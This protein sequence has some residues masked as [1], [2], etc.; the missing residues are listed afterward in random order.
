MKVKYYFGIALAS[1]MMFSCSEDTMDRINKD[2]AHP[3]ANVVTGVFQ[4]TDAEVATVYSTLCGNYAWYV[5]SY[6]E[7]LFGTGNNQL[8]NVEVRQMAQLAGS[9]VFTNEWN[10]TYLNLNNIIQIEEKCA[11]GGLND[12]QTDLLGMAQVLEALN[13][14]TLTDLH[15]DIPF[16]ECFKGISAPKVDT[17]E[18]IYNHIFDLLDKAVINLSAGGSHVGEHDILFGGNTDKW[19]G[20]AHALKARYLLHT[21]G[22]NRNVLTDV[23]TEANAALSAGFSG[24]SLSVFNGV[25]ADNSW[26]AYWWSRSYIGCSA[27]VDNL[28]LERND[29]REPIYNGD[30]FGENLVATPGDASAASLTEAV[31]APCWL[32]NGAASLHVFSESELYFILAE[33]KARLG[34]DAKTDFENGIKAAFADWIEADGGISGV[35]IVDADID[36][37]ISSLSARYTANPLKEIMVQKYIAQTRD[38]QLETYNDM[39]RCIYTD[40]SYAVEMTNPNNTA[41]GSNRWPYRL[42]YGESDVTSNPNVTAA[43]GTGNQAGVYVF[44]EP[45]WWA[46]GNK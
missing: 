12:G 17:Q 21:Y 34:Q 28:L 36:A 2:E 13:W 37:Y 6:T 32:E 44:S 24:C 3:G 31:N 16:S 35:E 11:E 41:S 15:G 27:T 40:G 26:S 1:L 5:S 9:S 46:G 43:F 18:D 22:V 20:L 39:R 33:A 25:T 45:V 42:P 23:L 30:M 19:L 10:A 7:Q 14:G 8:K 4:L 38:E 29:P